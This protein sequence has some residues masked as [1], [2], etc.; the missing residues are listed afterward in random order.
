MSTEVLQV[1]VKDASGADKGRLPFAPERLDCRVRHR[2]LKEAVVMYEANRRVGTHETKTRG[3]VAGS[4]KKLYRQKGTGRA[5][6][7]TRKS[8]LRRGG[9]T[10]FGPHPRDYS[11]AIPRKQR[12]LA[13]RSALLSKFRD[14]QV[15]VLDG[16]ALEKPRTRSVAEALAALG[17]SGTCLIG[18]SGHD[19]NLVLSARN[20]P[21][22]IVAPVEEFNARDVLRVRTIV[23]LRSAFDALSAEDGGGSAAGDASGGE[24]P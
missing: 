14:G 16:L 15:V 2:L 1:P 22:V 21:D 24:E 8:P 6:A 5:R 4:T 23:L 18:T 19:R 17:V 10:V 7:G 11:Y 12:Q 9:G 13:L 3:Q 20:I